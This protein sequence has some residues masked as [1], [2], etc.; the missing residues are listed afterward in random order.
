[1]IEEHTL[2]V[3][4]ADL[5]IVPILH[6]LNQVEYVLYVH[7]KYMHYKKLSG[8]KLMTGKITTVERVMHMRVDP[9][10]TFVVWQ[11]MV[12]LLMTNLLSSK[13]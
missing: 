2:G 11:M 6:L 7:P 1:M 10:T 3:R 8:K 12:I 5:S 4:G 9:N 13:S